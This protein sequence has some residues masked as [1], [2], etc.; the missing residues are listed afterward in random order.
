MK[1][2]TRNETKWIGDVALSF[3]M[4]SDLYDDVP[5]YHIEARRLERTIQ[6]GRI[7]RLCN[8]WLRENPGAAE[9]NLP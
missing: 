5:G 2:E 6:D 3:L 1:N 4:L 7:A 9:W 8:N